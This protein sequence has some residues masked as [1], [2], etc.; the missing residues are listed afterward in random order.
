V[1]VTL[2]TLRSIYFIF[3][4]FSRACACFLFRANDRLLRLHRFL[5]PARV[6]R[7]EK[8]KVCVCVALFFSISIAV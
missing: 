3:V 8:A 1:N 5:L 6:F 4:S 7:L 2:L